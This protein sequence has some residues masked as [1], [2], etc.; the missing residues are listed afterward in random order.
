MT[1][2]MQTSLTL[3]EF[4]ALPQGKPYV[5]LVDGKA[6]PK[7]SPQRFHS[8]TTRAL[9]ALLYDWCQGQGEVGIEW[10][11]VL[12]RREKDW[13]PIP[14]VLY[15]SHERLVMEDGEDGPCPVPPD[16]AVEVISPDQSFGEMAEKAMDYLYAGVL[17]VWVVDPRVQSFTVFVSDSLPITY[18]GE[19]SIRDDV[20]PGLEFS[21]QAFFLNAG[22]MAP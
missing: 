11:V 22:L 1:V 5:E 6:I 7:M 15:I 10:A 3:K 2:S 19:T 4:L 21:A 9:S 12:K 14:D 8:K 17:R 20:L 18:R 16:L 13:V